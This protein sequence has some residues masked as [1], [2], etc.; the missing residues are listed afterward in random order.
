MNE[1]ITDPQFG[2][3]D[4]VDSL[5][6]II[7]HEGITITPSV[8]DSV[9]KLDVLNTKGANWHGEL[10]YA[11]FEVN[12][13]QTYIVTFSAKAKVSFLFS[14]WLGQMNHPWASLTPDSN[15]FGEQMMTPE[16]QTFT[17]TWTPNKQETQARLNFVL[18][19]IDNTIEIK[20]VSLKH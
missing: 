7:C 11:P 4:T 12:P 6:Q 18:G 19:P 8:L 14:V 15:H 1:V 17:H 9:L 13:P 3:L 5:W 16:W 10:R 20:N 2:T